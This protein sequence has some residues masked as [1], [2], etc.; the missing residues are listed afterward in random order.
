MEVK[1]VAFLAR[2]AMAEETYGAEAWRAFLQ[3]FAEREPVFARPVMP[4]TRLPVPAFLALHEALVDTFHGGDPQAYWRFGEAAGVHALRHGRMKGLFERGEFQRF[5][6]FM[7]SSWRG[8]F[9]DG[10]LD[11]KPAEGG[12][13][14]VHI[15]G[16]PHP[17]LY[18]EYSIMG[19][20][21]AGLLELGAG[22]VELEP[23]AGYSRGDAE[24]RYRVTLG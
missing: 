6:Q 19:F 14:E 7:P 2:Q 10:Q 9:T 21:R 22:R 17:H 20:V 1:G 23:L 24:V 8:Y 11:V 15:H 4:V 5:L 12:G 3:R 13:T 16:V 18:F